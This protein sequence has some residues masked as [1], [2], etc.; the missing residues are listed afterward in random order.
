MGIV[1]TTG[2]LGG[3]PTAG[4]FREAQVEAFGD[5]VEWTLG[6]GSGRYFVSSQDLLCFSPSGSSAAGCLVV[7]PKLVDAV[8]SYVH[9]SRLTGHYSIRR[10]EARV[11]GLYWR[12]SWRRD[13][14]KKIAGCVAC[15]AVK[16][17]RPR[18]GAQMV[19]YHP[20]HRFQ[21]VAVDVQTITLRT[22]AGNIKVLVMIDTCGAHP[23]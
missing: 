21:Q 2:A 19:V 11:M 1:L 15:T 18:R 8:L 3:G 17:S 23:G 4:Q 16:A 9:G 22:Q 13:V 10:T 14:R 12:P 7:P 6:E 20:G 5:L